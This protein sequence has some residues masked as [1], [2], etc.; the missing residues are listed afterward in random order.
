MN[1][2]GMFD[3]IPAANRVYLFDEASG[4]AVDMRRQSSYAFPLDSTSSFRVLYGPDEYIRKN[5]PITEVQVA[6]PFPNPFAELVQIPV[7]LPGENNTYSVS[8]QIYSPQGVLIYSERKVSL[9]SGIHYFTWKGIDSRGG[10]AQ[11]GMYVCRME[12]TGPGIRREFT[13]KIIVK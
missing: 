3:K 12:V 13:R 8:M 6:E 10:Q 2:E 9:E 7:S 11:S 5:L 4:K 1:W